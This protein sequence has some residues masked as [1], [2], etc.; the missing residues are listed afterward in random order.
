M[1]SFIENVNYIA[2]LDNNYGDEIVLTK[3]KRH[4]SIS[5]NGHGYLFTLIP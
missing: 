3:N 4:L 2:N 1:N 5:D